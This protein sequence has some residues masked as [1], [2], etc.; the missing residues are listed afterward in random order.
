[1]LHPM[2]ITINIVA[3]DPETFEATL[4]KEADWDLAILSVEAESSVAEIWHSIWT[5]RAVG[6]TCVG[7]LRDSVLLTHLRALD[8]EA[9]C[10][11]EKL[12]AFLNYVAEKGYATGLAQKSRPS[13]VPVSV[14][15]AYLTARGELLPGACNYQ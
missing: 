2:S 4:Q 12:T 1:M 14:T 9:D 11:E 6:S 3:T 13:V 15:E 8:R 5:D 10:S 7:F